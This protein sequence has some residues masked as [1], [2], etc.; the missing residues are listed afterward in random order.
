M[1]Y[2]S[3]NDSIVDSNTPLYRTIDTELKDLLRNN[4]SKL[5]INYV[6]IGQTNTILFQGIGVGRYNFI[7]QFNNILTRHGCTVNDSFVYLHGHFGITQSG[8]GARITYTRNFQCIHFKIED[9]I[10]NDTTYIGRLDNDTISDDFK[11][12]IN[13]ILSRARIQ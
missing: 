8:R 10:Y 6:H 1:I 2:K 13:S 3:S 12:R 5:R 4:Y 9:D 7:A 11:D